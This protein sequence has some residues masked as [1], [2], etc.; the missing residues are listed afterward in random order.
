MTGQVLVVDDDP[1]VRKLLARALTVEGFDVWEAADGIEAARALGRGPDLVLLDVRLGAD[2]GLDV[3][4]RLRSE[5]DV[6]V[7]LVS[8]RSE[9]SDRVLGLKLGAD[10][11]VVKPFS[12]LELVARVQTVLRRAGPRLGGSIG[13]VFDE[14]CV[15]TARREV[16]VRGRRVE[17]TAKEF[18]LLAFLAASPGQVFS[19][20]QL[21]EH[22]WS[23]SS[24]W[25]D[26]AT[27]TEHVRRVRRRI[28]DDP[29]R[30][31]W[32]TTVRGVGY[33]FEAE[34]LPRRAPDPAVAS[35]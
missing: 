30:P 3:L 2:D 28:E 25:Q 19:R 24:A 22:V 14:L 33:R 8:G 4:A 10:D 26:D 20:E 6:P 7:I 13:M 15:D 5:S 11:Y 9:A 23:S 17:M 18:D 29:L 35:R 34:P 1:D 27:V 16:V 32:I 21:L 31:V 12:T